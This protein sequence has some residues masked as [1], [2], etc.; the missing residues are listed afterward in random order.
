MMVRKV[1]KS[2]NAKPSMKRV[3]I[4]TRT[5]N[6]SIGIALLSPKHKIERD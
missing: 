3:N 5:K 6:A 1:I 4:E 2:E